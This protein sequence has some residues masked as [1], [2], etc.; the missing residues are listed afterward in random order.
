M[1]M[2][3]TQTMHTKEEL[4]ERDDRQQRDQKLRLCSRGLT[5]PI[6]QYYNGV[7]Q[8]ILVNDSSGWNSIMNCYC[9][10]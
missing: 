3:S 6:I 9:F 5:D 2:S 7:Q 1:T 8:Y 4:E 10:H